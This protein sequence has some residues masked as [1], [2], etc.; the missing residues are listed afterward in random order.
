VGIELVK[1]PRVLFLD[2]PTSGKTARP[3]CEPVGLQ[4]G[5]VY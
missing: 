3:L 1:S 5:L 4:F 2:E